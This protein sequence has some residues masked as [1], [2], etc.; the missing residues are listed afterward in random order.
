MWTTCDGVYSA[1]NTDRVFCAGLKDSFVSQL[2]S[3][4]S[5]PAY[6]AMLGDQVDVPSGRNKTL[7]FD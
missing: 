2:A 3:Y 1:C 6:I 7:T 4:R 5:S